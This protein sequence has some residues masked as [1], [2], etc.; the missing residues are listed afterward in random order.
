MGRHGGIPQSV[1]VPA[2]GTIRSTRNADAFLDR[3]WR[4]RSGSSR[5]R[6]PRSEQPSR[7]SARRTSGIRRRV[8]RRRS[9]RLVY[10]RSLRRSGATLRIVALRGWHP[11]GE[12]VSTMDRNLPV[13]GGFGKDAPER[14]HRFRQ[15]SKGKRCRRKGVRR[16]N[17]LAV[18][19]RDLGMQGTASL[20]RF[21]TMF[22]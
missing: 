10:K 6:S 16:M 18:L 1:G 19:Y 14:C 8:R 13:S 17:T 9:W 7:R 20:Q 2:Q 12:A 11:Y 15:S 4:L 3:R 21:A 22:C 5:H